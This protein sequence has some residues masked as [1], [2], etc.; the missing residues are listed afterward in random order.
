[1]FY[2]VYCYDMPLVFLQKIKSSVSLKS[3]LVRRKDVLYKKLKTE[4]VFGAYVFPCKDLKSNQPLFNDGLPSLI[5]MP[6]KSD[7][8][9]LKEKG[10]TIQ[11]KSAWVCCG[12]IKDTHWE[13]PKDLEYILVLRFKPS[14]FY[15]I[16]NIDPAVFH[17]KPIRN[18]EDIIDEN[19]T[20]VFDKMYEMK[21][22]SE[23]T[24]F[25]DKALSKCQT[26]NN[27]PHILSVAME[28]I[29]AKRGNT[30]VSEVLHQLG[31]R[32]NS[33]WLYRNFVK[34]IGISPK[35]YISL[36]RFIY[37][38][39]EYE[40]NKSEESFDVAS[41]SG[42]YDCNHFFKDFKRYIGIAASQYAWD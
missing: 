11:F 30:T 17:S 1:M 6:R 27:F 39:G 5:F 3:K 34:Y 23:K 8:V 22:I 42:Y 18:L 20:Q 9:H 31:K 36:H 38:Y 35:K 29:E 21:T 41:L 40:K 32:V 33:K 28:Y 24:S 13:V 16:F 12:V 19:W 10:E 26:G 2:F 7:T 25:L 37:T 14:S 4:H 15:S